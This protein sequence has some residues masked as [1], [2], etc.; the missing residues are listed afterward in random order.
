MTA[1][2]VKVAAATVVV[3]VAIG[4]STLQQ[5][6]LPS[7]FLQGHTGFQFHTT[8]ATSAVVQMRN[9]ILPVIPNRMTVSLGSNLVGDNVMVEETTPFSEISTASTFSGAICIAITLV[10]SVLFLLLGDPMLRTGAL[11]TGLVGTSLFAFGLT[12]ARLEQRVSAQG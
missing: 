7:G 5:A 9:D 4:A 10:L 3:T 8:F 2:S 12:K 1:I 6:E 11:F